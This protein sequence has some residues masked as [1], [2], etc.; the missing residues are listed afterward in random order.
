MKTAAFKRWSAQLPHLNRQQRA[1][2]LA[3]IQPAVSLDRVCT[4]INATRGVSC[5]CAHC[6]AARC[7]RHGF[8]RG[9]QRYRCRACGKTFTA[10]TG[11]PL[12]R[13]R[14]QQGA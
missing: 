12:A 8:H 4:L 9:L 1:H 5:D 6:G 11:T 3:L 13:L 2:L 7:Y 10:L 14:H